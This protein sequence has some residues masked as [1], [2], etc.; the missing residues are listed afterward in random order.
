MKTLIFWRI[1]AQLS[2]LLSVMSGAIAADRTQDKIRHAS[3]QV[4][5]ID[6][7]ISHKIAV[8]LGGLGLIGAELW[9]FLRRKPTSQTARTDQGIQE[10]TVIVNGGYEPNQVI[11][12]AGHLVRLNF[13]RKDPSSCLEEIRI[14]DFKIAQ[15]L[16]LNQITPIEFTPDKPG[17]YEFS[18]G[19]NMFRGIVEVQES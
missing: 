1:L 19:M 14:P 8:T 5:Q 4:Q 7:P 10:V 6:Q 15:K 17:R 12:K 16:L 13:D 18:C 11:V 2:I 3:P 9:W